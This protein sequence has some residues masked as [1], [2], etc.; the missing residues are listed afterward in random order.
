M[1]FKYEIPI[2]CQEAMDHPSNGHGS[3]KDP[4]EELLHY[5]WP[6][7]LKS[8]AGGPEKNIKLVNGHGIIDLRDVK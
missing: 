8:K 3:P 2:H 6:T 5:A 1:Q 7:F 4:I